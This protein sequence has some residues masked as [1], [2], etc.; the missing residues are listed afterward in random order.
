MLD[1][2]SEEA[3]YHASDVRSFEAISSTQRL[4]LLGEPGIGKSTALNAE[5]RELA[6]AI[7][8][9]D[10]TLWFDLRD[11][12]SDDRLERKVFLQ[13]RPAL[14]QRLSHVASFL[15]IVSMRDSCA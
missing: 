3:K 9:T 6:N 11:Y 7:T 13:R 14:E 1:P 2:E 12:S 5:W 10:A 8:G 4:V 15:W